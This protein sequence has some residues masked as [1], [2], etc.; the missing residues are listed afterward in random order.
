MK[1]IYLI[2]F[3]SFLLTSF[4]AQVG[5]NT[6]RPKAT[7]HVHEKPD[8][9][10][11][12]GL[13]LPRI[14]GDSLRLK[15]NAYGLD[16]NGLLIYV[17]SPTTNNSLKTLNVDKEG[18]YMYDGNFVHGN[19]TLGTWMPMEGDGSQQSNA[20]DAYAVRASGNL[21]LLD[22]GINLL[23]SAVYTLPIIANSAGDF[24]VGIPSSQVANNSYI[25]PSDGIY[26]INYS[27]RT[28][29]G[30]RAELLSGTRPGLIITKTSGNTTNTLD[31][32]LFGGVNLL[33]LS[34][35]P[36]VVN[37]SL[38]QGQIS[39]IYKLKAGDVLKFGVL[40]GGLSLGVLTDSSAE[41]S[42]YKIR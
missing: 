1:K 42:I 32:R 15:D 14:S 40:R 8:L 18:M 11:P 30:I 34:P 37:I 35:L 5:I 21:S 28:G 3:T 17:T 2:A 33:D 4:N 16:Q 31:S 12:D 6:E 9:N 26:D 22:L 25:V 7:L 41:L 13:I 29:Q 39:H 38:T 36:S 27:Y 23:G 10:Y 19:N 24:N 20:T